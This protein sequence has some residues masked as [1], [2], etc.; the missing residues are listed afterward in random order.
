MNATNK[1]F[2]TTNG[3]KQECLSALVFAF[4]FDD[5]TSHC[6]S[7]NV[8]IFL[9]N[10]FQNILLVVSSTCELQNHLDITKLFCKKYDNKLN[11]SKSIIVRMGLK[12]KKRG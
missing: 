6:K 12:C 11:D 8:S 3:L 4:S 10:T 7:S 1:L 5:M 2:Y 9:N